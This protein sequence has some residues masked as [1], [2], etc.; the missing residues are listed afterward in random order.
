LGI[1]LPGLMLSEETL[2]IRHRR[3][4]IAG[5]FTPRPDPGKGI[6]PESS[7]P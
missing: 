6:D 1:I 7:H 2:E 5:G 4:C 3:F